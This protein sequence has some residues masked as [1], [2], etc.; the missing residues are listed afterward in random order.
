MKASPFI[1]TI[2]FLLL[3][4]CGDD[5]QS[6]SK[7]P[8]DAIILAFGDS[9]TYGTGA[10][11]DES[12][13]VVLQELTHLKVINAGIPGE[14][15]ESGLYRLSELL[16]QYKPQLLILCHGGNDLLRKKNIIKMESNIRAM[17][18]L[19]KDKNISV[20]ILGVPKPGLFLSSFEVYEKIAMS[21]GITFIED[22]IPKVLGDN[23]L[24]SDAVHPNKFGYRIMAE[25]IH[26]VLKK[27][28]A[29]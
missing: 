14:E 21:T 1:S 17:I 23:S 20:V 13:P 27:S 12:Y 22:L 19:A 15:S 8:D 7:L 29:I 25:T 3:S 6:I 9:L 16:E 2:L 4:A 5:M 11:D 26:S 28:G 18:K 24:K 10:K